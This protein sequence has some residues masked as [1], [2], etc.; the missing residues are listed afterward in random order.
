MTQDTPEWHAWRR[1]GIGSSDAAA[2]L[3]LCPYRTIL[4]VY[5]DKVEGAETYAHPGMLRGKRLE[6]VAR[7]DYEA[8]TGLVVQP[9]TRTHGALDWMRASYDGLTFEGDHGVEIKV[10]GDASYA[11]IQ[12]TGCPAHYLAQIQ[13]QYAVGSLAGVQFWGWH[14]DREPIL[15]AV[16]RDD[17]YIGRLIEAE[18]QF[19][20]CVQDRVPPPDPRAAETRTDQPWLTAA[21]EYVRAEAIIAEWSGRKDAAREVLIGMLG[22]ATRARGG[23]V[24]LTKYVRKG[25]VEYRRVPQ[26]KG[27][28]L[29]PYRGAATEAVRVTLT[30]G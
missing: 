1:S 5:R 6:G 17:E 13:H 7:A 26:L 14:P 24:A 22:E 9:A 11:A 29:D 2:I 18:Q 12:S 15:I 23:G 3:G 20:A 4:D 27:V 19:W 8:A 25:N 28:D 30:E 21:E 10:L 16:P